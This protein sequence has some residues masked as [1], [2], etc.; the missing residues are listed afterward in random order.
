MSEATIGLEQAHASK[1]VEAELHHVAESII[2]SDEFRAVECGIKDAIYEVSR[3]EL[4]LEKLVTQG[5]IGYIEEMTYDERAELDRQI[6]LY[7]ELVRDSKRLEAALIAAKN[8]LEAEKGR[9]RPEQEAARE[10]IAELEAEIELKPF[11]KDYENKKQDFDKIKTQADALLSTLED[12]KKGIHVGADVLR[13]VTK[14]LMEGI[15][16]IR[17]IYVETSSDA[18]AENKP[19]IFSI[20]VWWL[21]QNHTCRVE[22]SPNQEAHEL[23]SNAAEKV[24]ALADG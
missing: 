3:F 15:P 1:A 10:R 8:A 20:T 16:E 21:G 18:L 22:W 5:P 24:V 13:Q 2:N 9:L 4:A 23:Y 7:N 19:I 14:M 6:S 17:D 11:E 12:I